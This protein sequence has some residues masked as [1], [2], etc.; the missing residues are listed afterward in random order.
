MACVLNGQLAHVGESVGEW[1]IEQI[2]GSQVWV[3]RG[4]ERRRLDLP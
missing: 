4:S 3:S 2:D 1:T